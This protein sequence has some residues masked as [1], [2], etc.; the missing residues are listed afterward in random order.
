MLYRSNEIIFQFQK[1]KVETLKI[2]TRQ[3]LLQAIDNKYEIL[4][5]LKSHHE[6]EIESL[7][8]TIDS[9]QVTFCCFNTN[10]V[11]DFISIISKHR[12]NFD[13]LSMTT[14]GI[15]GPIGRGHEITIND[16]HE[17][18]EGSKECGG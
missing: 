13:K 6:S 17:A 7:T 8:H 10:I 9:L 15:A 18:S 11:W 2:E 3:R 14:T 5:D 16:D 1:I 4:S 12:L